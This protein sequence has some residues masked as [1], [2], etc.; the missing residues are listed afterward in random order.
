MRKDHPNC[1]T[2]F[3]SSN[4]CG[5]SNHAAVIILDRMDKGFKLYKFKT[6]EPDVDS[7]QDQKY[8]LLSAFKSYLSRKSDDLNK[9]FKAVDTENSG[10][11][12]DRSI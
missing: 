10:F 2:I 6:V 7:L 9:I 5:G 3:S 8:F 1:L 12:F 4:Y 11:L